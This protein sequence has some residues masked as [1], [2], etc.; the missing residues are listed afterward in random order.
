MTY[1]EARIILGLSPDD[2]PEA[3]RRAYLKLMIRARPVR[4]PEV[5]IV[6]RKHAADRMALVEEAYKML[7]GDRELQ[8]EAAYEVFLRELPWLMKLKSRQQ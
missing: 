6:D 3:T 1:D 5:C 2:P 8:E 4:R 7:C